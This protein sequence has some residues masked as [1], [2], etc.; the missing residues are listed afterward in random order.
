M[1]KSYE[2]F[3]GKIRGGTFTYRDAQNVYP[4]VNI[5]GSA[6]LRARSIVPEEGEDRRKSGLRILQILRRLI[7]GQKSK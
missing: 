3:E 2:Q 7:L 5:A 4:F 1:K 6:P